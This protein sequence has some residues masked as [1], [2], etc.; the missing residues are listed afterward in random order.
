MAIKNN[1]FA[2]LYLR[3]LFILMLGLM[4]L[5]LV[6][7][8]ENDTPTGTFEVGV[9]G[10]FNISQIDGDDLVGYNR[11]G[12]FVGGR[13]AVRF[14]PLWEVSLEMLYAQKGSETNTDQTILRGKYKYS[15][16]YVE[17]PIML[18]YRDGGILFG[19]G[20]SY[21]RL[22]RLREVTLADIDQ[23]ET[24][25]PFYR[26]NEVALVGDLGYFINKHV[27]FFI[28]WQRSL[29]SI[30]DYEATNL[31]SEPQVIRILS[32]RGVYMF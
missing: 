8:E 21:G 24:Y 22:V 5:L 2:F 6:A 28:R 10:G 3:H 7:Q 23:T 12:L 14:K 9:V 11:F 16:D 1:L 18:N 29:F 15:L 31:L 27:G 32:F 17:I 30:V 20:L 13:V 25:S 19:A 4:P 26:K